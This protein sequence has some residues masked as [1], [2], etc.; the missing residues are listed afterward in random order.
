MCR[1]KSHWCRK[2]WPTS[3][4]NS[5]WWSPKIRKKLWTLQY[6]AWIANEKK[7]N[8]WLANTR[9]PNSQSEFA[10]RNG[11]QKKEISTACWR[12]RFWPVMAV[13]HLPGQNHWFI[14]VG[15]PNFLHWLN[16]KKECNM[17]KL[18]KLV[19]MIFEDGL[20]R[21]CVYKYWCPTIPIPSTL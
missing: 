13:Q 5:I 11:Q 21:S 2:R 7:S 14:R 8:T 10:C 12:P 17:S 20:A 9:L 6:I 1:N 19:S 3:L 4:L 16:R 18:K 15:Y